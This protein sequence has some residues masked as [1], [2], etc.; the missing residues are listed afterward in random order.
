MTATDASQAAEVLETI[1]DPVADNPNPDLGQAPRHDATPPEPAER[2]DE[3]ATGPKPD[4]ARKAIAERMK[5]RRN[6]TPDPEFEGDFS[7]PKAMYGREGVRHAGDPEPVPEPAAADRAA[8]PAAPEA[9]PE[10]KTYKLKV[11]HEERELPEDEVLAL[12]QKAAASDSYFEEGRRYLDDAKRL[13]EEAA[14]ATSRPHQDG[15]SAQHEHVPEPTAGD[16]H[17]D[18][19]YAKLAEELQLGDPKEVGKKLQAT[20]AKAVAEQTNSTLVQSAIKE[21]FQTSMRTLDTFRKANPEIASDPMAEAAME[22]LVYDGYREDLQ[23]IGVTADRMPRDPKQL[24][25]WHRFYRVQGQE[26]RSTNDLLNDAKGKFQ[27]WRGTP[28]PAPTP[29]APA[30]TARVVVDRT[31]RRAAI[32]TQPT[33]ATTPAPAQQS[34]E[35]QMTA[36]QKA[37]M[38]AR[39]SR[40]Q[41]VA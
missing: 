9:T 38:N 32:P 25:D 24:A 2:R 27:E 13:H 20:I 23:K 11:R 30:A 31:E 6:G 14:R 22:R 4:D 10:K 29:A 40:G 5:A 7:D 8:E 28:K 19:H 17:Q 34:A 15:N 3:I 41:V 33:R 18:D 21:D 1:S 36:R 35:P 37:V 26:V 39:K 16:P 12:A